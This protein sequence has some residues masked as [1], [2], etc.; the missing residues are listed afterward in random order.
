MPLKYVNLTGKTIVISYFSTTYIRCTWQYHNETIF[1][2]LIIF[3]CKDLNF[4][5]FTNFANCSTSNLIML[6]I[7]GNGRP[8]ACAAV[9]SNNES[10][11][12]PVFWMT[13]HRHHVHIYV[14]NDANAY[15]VMLKD[16]YMQI[17]AIQ[18]ICRY[19]CKYKHKSI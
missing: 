4:F 11:K 16:I 19:M 1:H 17:H 15:S 5:T 8:R 3:Y 14:G 18:W 2:L 12:A 6:C 10:T 13:T 7:L 9:D